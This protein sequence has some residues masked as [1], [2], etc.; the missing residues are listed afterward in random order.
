MEK[1]F[2][3]PGTPDDDNRDYLPERIKG[4]DIVVNENGNNSQAYPERLRE[5]HDALVGDGREDTWYEYIPAGYDPANKTPLVISLHGGLMTGWGQAIYTSWTMM[6]EALDFIVAFPDAS[7]GRVWRV[8]WGKWRFD[9]APGTGGNEAPPPGAGLSPENVM[10]NRDVK[11]ILGVLSR[12]K[13]KYNIDE[14]RI[15]LQ[16]MSM[17]NLMTALFFR[18]LGNL[19][20]GAAGSGCAGFTNLLFEPDGTIK[21]EG[22][23]L[24]VWQSRPENND[25]P[26]DKE[27]SLYV[28]KYNRYYWMKLNG[29]GALPQISILGEDNLAFYTGE[30]ADMVYL[31]I[32]NRDHGQ[33]LDDAA[34]V[35]N[36]LFSGV[37][38]K[39]DGSIVRE[40][41]N[42][43][44]RGDAFALAVATGCRYAWANGRL[45]P[46]TAAART[47]QKLKY[48]GLDGGQKVRG[49]Y[50]MAPLSLLADFFGAELIC[51]EGG[52]TARMR[53]PDGRQLQFARGS[54]GCVI[55]GDL[56]SMYCEALHRNGE[57]LV[58]I[59]WFSRYLLNLQASEC[60]GVVY[61]A[62]HFS[63]LSANMADVLRELLYGKLF[64]E[65]FRYLEYEEVKR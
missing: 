6:A 39:A 48:H 46:M 41:S 50:C 57:L 17:G 36:Y 12:M 8:Q 40:R 30:K 34:L 58:S 53:L 2:L 7:E 21:N 54:I 14:E 49:E 27:E 23:H 64:P 11:L 60:D 51:G 47:W 25:I 13:E 26:P 28:N 32:K 63:T 1:L 29:C 43:P 38:R 9:G 59:E 65:H 52:L 3:R 31:D 4:S 15:Y 5:F 18:G 24:P 20:A 33:T 55:D 42:L 16:G 10:E 37:R 61:V 56:R 44:R 45:L 35:W 22:G 19:L 62:D